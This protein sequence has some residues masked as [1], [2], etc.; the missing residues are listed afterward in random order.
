MVFR[1]QIL[2]RK[3]AM[4]VYTHC[5]FPV[6]ALI[7][8]LFFPVSDG[9]S[10]FFLTSTNQEFTFHLILYLDP[11]WRT[12][13]LHWKTF[14]Q[15]KKHL[16]ITQWCAFLLRWWWVYFHWW[17]RCVG[18]YVSCHDSQVYVLLSLPDWWEETKLSRKHI[19]TCFCFTHMCDPIAWPSK[20]EGNFEK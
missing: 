7:M 17:W 12:Y 5:G 3:V 13:V 6:A 14:N 2:S 8:R 9:I 11:N 20:R 15:L 10:V 1:T 16:N 19:F 4:T 18:V